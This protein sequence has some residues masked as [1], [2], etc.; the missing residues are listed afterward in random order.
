MKRL[1]LCAL[2]AALLMPMLAWA[3]EAELPEQLPGAPLV[4]DLAGILSSSQE[5]NDSLLAFEQAHDGAQVL[6]VT[7]SDLLGYTPAEYAAALGDKWG[8]GQKDKDNG[9]VILIKEKTADSKGEFFIAPGRGLEGVLPDAIC[10]RITENEMIPVIK[11]TGD[12]DSVA[13]IA[14]KAVTTIVAGGEFEFTDRS[15][16][17]DDIDGTTAL[18]GGGMIVLV[19]GLIVR[20]AIKGGS[21]G[22]GGGS[23]H[24]YG[25]SGGYSG[26]GSSHS[27]GGGSFSGGGGGSSW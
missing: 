2:L 20:G 24:Y 27:Y 7:T 21:R 14:V 26:G 11:E 3:A 13:W 15:A 23:T 8:I 17:D 1:K 4:A 22:G 16:S 5:M 6:V 10:H 25:G 18:I 9:V 12:Y 19:L